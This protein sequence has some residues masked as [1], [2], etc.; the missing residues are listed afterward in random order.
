MISLAIVVPCYNEQEVLPETKQRLVELLQ[1]LI[2][3]GK[4]AASSKIYFIDDCSQDE[5]WSLIKSY[6]AESECICGIKL[7]RN[8]GHQNA[9]LAGLLTAKGQALVS[10][11]AD[12]QDDINVIENMVDDYIEQGA[13]IVYG[14][15]GCR[16]SDTAFKRISAQKFYQLLRALGVDVIDNHADFRLMGRRAI[17]VLRDFKEVNL[18]L[19]G[20]VPL[21]G[22]KTT[23][24]FY[25]RAP[26]F[27][28]TSKY[29]L[30]KM[31][32]LALD[33]I[34]SFS[35]TPLRVIT[36]LGFVVFFASILMSAW[37][38][39]RATFA[40]ATVPGW[41][42]VVLPIYFIG[43]VQI[44]CIGIIGEYIGKIYYEAKQRPRYI[45]E[46]EID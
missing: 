18:F 8:V 32:S 23:T 3:A 10:I 43:G 45:I 30:K 37:I 7:A 15:R 16:E 28:G 17:E 5:T 40:D 39:F 9:L 1:R 38:F 6:S 44:L 34:T 46:E 29:P 27:A 41:A 22:F 2:L 35:V 13:E 33:G 25:D 42:S 24:V 31:L 36:S 19:R 12:L 20:V 14:V 4:L 21:I 26:R 11:D